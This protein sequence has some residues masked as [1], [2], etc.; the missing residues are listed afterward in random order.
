MIKVKR[1]WLLKNLPASVVVELE[2]GTLK[3]FNKMLKSL[4]EADLKP[5]NSSHPKSYPR[6]HCKEF[7]WAFYPIFNLEKIK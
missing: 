6:T 7:G 1:A 5:Y 3:H 4:T 2:D